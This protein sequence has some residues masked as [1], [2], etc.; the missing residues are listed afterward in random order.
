MEI[1]ESVQSADFLKQFTNAISQSSIFGV[2][3]ANQA[4]THTNK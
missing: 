4:K 3:V 2:R 1:N